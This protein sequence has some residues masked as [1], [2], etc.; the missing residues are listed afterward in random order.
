MN[1]KNCNQEI[2]DTVK[3]CP[4]C[5]AE[6]EAS[7][8]TVQ[9]VMEAPVSAEKPK[10]K[11]WKLVALIAGGIL[12]LGILVTAVL[13]GAGILP[14][15]NDQPAADD[16]QAE[17]VDTENTEPYQ[18]RIVD[19]ETAAANAEVVVATMG[20]K[21]LTNGELQLYYQNL[22]YTFYNEYYYY[23]SYMGLD[24][25]RPLSEQ[26]CSVAANQT[27]EE[28]FIEG[29]IGNWKSYTL[30]EILAEQENF[31]A[32]DEL[33]AT[34][35]GIEDELKLYA[36]MDGFESLDA[37]IHDGMGVNV[38][39]ED[40]LHFNEVY[41]ISNEY[42]DSIYEAVYPTAD[43]IEAYY[44]AN[45]ATLNENGITKDMGLLSNVR[46][47]LVAVEGGTENEDGTVTYSDEEWN[48]ARTEAERILQEWK[49]G[50]A[51]E[52]S[53]AQLAATYTDDTASAVDGGLYTDV[54]IDSS[55]VP[56]FLNW[57]VDAARMPGD[58]E[59]VETQYGY[60][61]MYF[62][63]GEDYYSF[64]VAEQ[65]IA[66]VIREKLILAQAE[67]PIETDYSKIC[68][69]QRDIA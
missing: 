41:Y 23:M 52:E 4:H 59:I 69:A 3:F 21:E 26:E 29:A 1:C 28:Y 25:S 62:V 48:T 22:L 17:T 37:Y 43:E 9:V 64:L 40:Y 54:S 58:T 65:A 31:E 57:S 35:A 67:Y 61:I 42:L 18:T 34:L 19:D 56:N 66:D 13:Y 8:E 60:H 2:L 24:L 45:E 39:L 63:S 15:A 50:E 10:V 49:D 36:E 53:F 38:G 20:G 27:W 7:E 51:T 12:L 46:H 32:S 5:G 14:A 11:A 33:A 47:I 6:V 68:L 30:V 16:V 55:Y 44:T